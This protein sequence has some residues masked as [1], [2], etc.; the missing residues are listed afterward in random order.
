MPKTMLVTVSTALKAI[1][2]RDR[3]IDLGAVGLQRERRSPA[4]ATPMFPGVSGKVPASS[5][6]GTIRSAAASGREIPKA[7]TH[8]GRGGDPA[9]GREPDPAEQ[10]ARRAR[11]APESV[12]R[13]EHVRDAPRGWKLRVK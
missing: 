8:R 1:P 11:T 9:D 4:L 10:L 7:G 2:G 13:I 6:A 3:G 5:S 12:E